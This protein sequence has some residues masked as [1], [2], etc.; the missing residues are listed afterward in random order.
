MCLSEFSNRFIR[1]A[2]EL[3]RSAHPEC[4]EFKK[5]YRQTEDYKETIAAISSSIKKILKI[6]NLIYSKN[7]NYDITEVVKT[8]ETA[9]ADFNDACIHNVCKDND[10]ILLT[11]DFDFNR[12]SDI[13][14][15]SANVK[16]F[17]S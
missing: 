11:D 6:S 7:I 4:V 17:P 15:V 12:F 14:I 9:A 10:F 3:Y 8:Y 13:S 1:M 5:D 16:Y 2:F